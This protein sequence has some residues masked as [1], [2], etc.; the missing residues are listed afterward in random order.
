MQEEEDSFDA[1]PDF[2]AV[3]ASEVSSAN[4][5]QTPARSNVIN[6][7]GRCRKEPVIRVC[8][9]KTPIVVTGL[10][11]R[12]LKAASRSRPSYAVCA[13][14]AYRFSKRKKNIQVA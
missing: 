5:P 2:G 9:E 3:L 13:V 6:C 12:N 8:I 1:T 7:A 14:G 10:A 11:Q 4:A